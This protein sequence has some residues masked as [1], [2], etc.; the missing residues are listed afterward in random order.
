M[1]VVVL[2]SDGIRHKFFANSLDSKADNSL[3]ISESKQTGVKDN[4]V[5]SINEHFKLRDE[6][7]KL[8]FP[9]NYSFNSETLSIKYKELNTNYILEKIKEFEPDM[10]FVFGSSII[11]EPLLSL[12]TSIPTL[13]LHLGISPYYRGSGTNF[14]PFVNNELEYV[15]STI[16][17]I[18]S[19]I[20]TGDIIC[21]TR[22]I[23]ETGDN[24]HSVGCKVIQT[25]IESLFQIMDMV[26]KKIELIPIKQWSVEN[27]RYY[28]TTD[29][30]EEILQ[31]Y[32]NNLEND[33]IE[34]Y[35]SS[36]KKPLR[37]VSL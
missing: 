32:K 28:K 37:L 27:E 12:I 17:H 1:K 20:D 30:N 24:V 7:E 35:L 15:G 4:E 11:K 5:K 25:S 36:P 33:L 16:L 8:F 31:K 34:N 13:N 23:I 14:W 29:F 6:T 18:N 3:I 19:G 21:H 26:T 10:M 2:T 9:D 22:P